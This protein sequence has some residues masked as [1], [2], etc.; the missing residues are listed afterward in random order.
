MRLLVHV[1]TAAVLAILVAPAAAASLDSRDAD[2]L[3]TAMQIQLGRYA[4]ASYEAKHGSGVVKKFAAALAVRAAH[5]SRT[6]DG[7]AKQYGVTPEKGLLIQDKYHYSQ[8]QGLQGSALDKRFIREL[9]ISDNI[10]QDTEK[11]EIRNG[12][13]DKLKAYAKNRYA[14]VQHELDALEHF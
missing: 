13:S 5:D 6:L 9:R 1:F 4:V 10:N 11:Q 2:Y 14:A 7:L 8:I 3:K 12:R